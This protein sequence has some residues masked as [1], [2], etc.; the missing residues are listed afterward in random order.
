MSGMVLRAAVIEDVA[1]IQA[2]YAHH[3]ATGFGSFEETPPDLAEM[4]R[5]FQVLMD[6]SYPYLVATDG[7]GGPA[8]GYAYAGAYRPRSAYRHTVEDSVYVAP[9]ALGRGIGRALLGGLIA[10]A[11]ARGFRQMVAVI[12]DSG[13]T[14]S[15]GLHAA[16]G[17]EH[18]GTLRNVGL[19]RG[20]WL[21]T[22]LMQR[23]LVP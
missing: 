9:A 23:A 8:L 20:R 22:V 19:K 11:S 12:G 16:L 15:I 14:G 2:I 7:A 4:T 3:V 1:A 21:D 10:E 13:N 18:I 17:F 6:G 5:R